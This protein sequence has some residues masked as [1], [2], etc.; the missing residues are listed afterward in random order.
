MPKVDLIVED[1]LSQFPNIKRN[2]GKMVYEF[3]PNME[4]NKGKAVKWL[5]QTLGLEN[6]KEFCTIYVGDDTTDEDVFALFADDPNTSGVGILVTE[7]SATTKATLT[8][9][10]P[11]E[12]SL[13]L[14]KLLEYGKEVGA[15]PRLDKLPG[16]N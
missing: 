7:H 6:P 12:V 14:Q 15:S 13:F 9:R 4:W 3:K 5:L 2:N 8:L 10:N 1:V 16:T 11:N